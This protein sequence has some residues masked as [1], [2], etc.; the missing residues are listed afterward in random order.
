M[1][2]VTAREYDALL[3]DLDGTLLD[4]QDRIHPENLRALGA[5]RREGVVVMVVTGRSQ[6]SAR[7]VLDELELGT[8]AVLFNG[9]AVYC[10][11]TDRLREERVL[12]EASLDAL[13]THA[14]RTGDL[15]VWMT[16]D[17]KF[18]PA[19]IRPGDRGA[20]AGLP[21]V[22]FIDPDA[23]R[24]EYVIRVTFLSD[25][26]SDSAHLA[27]EIEQAVGRPLY[28]THF[29]LA[30]LPRHR[31]S[32]HQAVDVHAPCRGK[33]EALRLLWEDEGIPAER[34]VAVGDA[35]NDIPMIEAAGLGVA[36]G[37]GMGELRRIADRVI[38]HHDSATIAELVRE[39]FL[40]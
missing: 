27:A 32:A 12:S 30:V 9:A 16:R 29:P 34:V 15:T 10:P 17:R 26:H 6:L 39:L 35:T 38:G 40:G 37:S 11:R 13:Q 31:H 7:P 2:P 1:D 20:L 18:V 24:P 25:R 22:E 4:G 23:E 5:A 36:M 21:G 3:L 33:A 28:L 8:P 19:E 14:R